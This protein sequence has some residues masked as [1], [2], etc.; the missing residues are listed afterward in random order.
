MLQSFHDATKSG[1]TYNKK[2]MLEF[3]KAHRNIDGYKGVPNGFV[4][5]LNFAYLAF[6]FATTYCDASPSERAAAIDVEVE[7]A[8]ERMMAMLGL[9]HD[10]DRLVALIEKNNEELKYALRIIDE[11]MI[12]VFNSAEAPRVI[13]V[14]I[15]ALVNRSESM[16]ASLRDRVQSTIERL[17]VS[18][19]AIVDE[20]GVAPLVQYFVIGR[21]RGSFS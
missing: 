21:D 7:K 14:L 16:S 10:S 5:S 19:Q 17:S 6:S 9:P 12:D 15:N 11:P 13:G 2:F 18:T 3:V 20:A 1:K 8:H 4:A